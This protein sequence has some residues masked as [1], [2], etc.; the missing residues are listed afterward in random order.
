M[1]TQLP[2]QI[3]VTLPH[4]KFKLKDGRYREWK[5]NDLV[6]DIKALR[7]LAYRCKFKGP[8]YVLFS[9]KWTLYLE[10]PVISRHGLIINVNV[11]PLGEVISKL[12]GIMGVGVSDQ[13]EPWKIVLYED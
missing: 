9:N 13:L 7:E 5:P 4:E 8:F 11:R 3:K 1:P 6:T 12:Q 2:V 10:S